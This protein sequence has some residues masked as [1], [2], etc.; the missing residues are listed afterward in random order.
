M[1]PAGFME[2]GSGLKGHMWRETLNVEHKPSL[3][4]RGTRLQ[5]SLM[6]PAGQNL[7]AWALEYLGYLS[8]AEH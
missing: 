7:Q 8:Q 6:V 3:R 2:F 5:Q 4:L 1:T